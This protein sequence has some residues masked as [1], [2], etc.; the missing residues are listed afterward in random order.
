MET[1][2]YHGRIMRGGRCDLHGVHIPLRIRTHVRLHAKMPR[3]ALEVIS[4]SRFCSL[5]LVKESAWTM[6]ASTMEPF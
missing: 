4:E 1:G 2:L 6:V 5:F 3:V